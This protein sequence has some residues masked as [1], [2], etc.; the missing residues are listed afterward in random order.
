MRIARKQ[1]ATS[2]DLLNIELNQPMG[3]EILL[4]Q[5]HMSLS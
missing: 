1:E 5:L 3:M 4:E 2:I